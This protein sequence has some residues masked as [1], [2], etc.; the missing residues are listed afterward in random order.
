MPRPVDQATWT[1]PPQP[2]RVDVRACLEVQCESDTLVSGV[3]VIVI[4]R[5]C[6]ARGSSES[7]PDHNQDQPSAGVLRGDGGCFR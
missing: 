2:V 5:E 7:S 6:D 3:R 4:E 1:Q